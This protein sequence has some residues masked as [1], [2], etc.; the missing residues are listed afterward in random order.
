MIHKMIHVYLH[1]V[2]VFFSIPL[3]FFNIHYC[4]IMCKCSNIYFVPPPKTP[5]TL[6][7]PPKTPYCFLKGISI[8]I[9]NYFSMDLVSTQV[10]MQIKSVT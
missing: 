5:Y 8:Q 9:S 3:I 7:P 6:Y 4:A 1:K 2:Q 10:Q